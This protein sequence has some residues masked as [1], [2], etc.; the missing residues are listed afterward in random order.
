MGIRFKNRFKFFDRVSLGLGV[1]LEAFT[2]AADACLERDHDFADLLIA[3][4][5]TVRLHH[6]LETGEPPGDNRL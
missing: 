5:V 2:P 3:F 4:Q 1:D 6:L